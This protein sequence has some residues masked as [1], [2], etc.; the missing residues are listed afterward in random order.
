MEGGVLRAE[1][2]VKYNKILPTMWDSKE[3]AFKKINNLRDQM[4]KDLGAPLTII[5]AAGHCPNEDQPKDTA[6]VLASFWKSL[7]TL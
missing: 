5:K 1:D 6:R 7:S 2:E 3:T 4:A